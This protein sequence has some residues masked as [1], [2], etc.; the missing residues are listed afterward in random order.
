[1]SGGFADYIHSRMQQ[2]A[3]EYRKEAMIRQCIQFVKSRQKADNCN[4]DD[5]RTILRENRFVWDAE[6][7]D[8]IGELYESV[9]DINGEIANRLTWYETEDENDVHLLRF[10]ADKLEEVAKLEKTADWYVSGDDSIEE[11]RDECERRGYQS[12]SGD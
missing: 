2:A 9:R 7:L 10:V 11:F 12:T 8:C 6:I 4:D 3:F 5:M 1:M